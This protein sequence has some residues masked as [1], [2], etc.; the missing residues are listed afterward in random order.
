MPGSDENK[1]PEKEKAGR[2]YA[3]VCKSSEL[4]EGKGRQFV[5]SEDEDMQIAAFRIKGK[6]YALSNICP[7]RHQ[8]K[9]HEGIINNGNIVCPVHGWTYN[10]ETGRNINL[11]QGIKSL[12]K[13]DIYEEDGYIWAEKPDNSVI[14]VWRREEPAE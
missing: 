8:D 14:P 9:I 7:H 10:I 3:R 6:L 11:K 4:F 5:F 13:Y 2:I 12:N 1:Y